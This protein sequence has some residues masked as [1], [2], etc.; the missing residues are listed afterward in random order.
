M[1]DLAKL[2]RLKDIVEDCRG[3]LEIRI[4]VPGGRDYYQVSFEDD[5]A[6]YRKVTACSGDQRETFEKLWPSLMTDIM[7]QKNAC[8]RLKYNDHPPVWFDESDEPGA[9]ERMLLHARSLRKSQPT[10]GGEKQ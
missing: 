3:L 6:A 5:G 4:Y 8:A 10:Q 1:F 7:N 9:F 2:E